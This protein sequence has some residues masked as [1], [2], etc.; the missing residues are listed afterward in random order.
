VD[1]DGSARIAAVRAHVSALLP[2]KA[3]PRRIHRVNT[4]RDDGLVVLFTRRFATSTRTAYGG[5]EVVLDLEGKLAPNG[6]QQ[7]RVLK[8]RKGGGNTTLRWGQAV[9]SV[10][11]PSQ[12][13]VYQLRVGQRFELRTQ[14]V[15][16]VDEPCGG[17]TAV[18][19]GW[20]GVS[21][22]QG[23]NYFTLR[24]GR[25]AAPSRTTYASGSQ[26]HPRTGLGITADGRVL[27]VT[28]DGRRTASAGVTLAEMGQLMRSLGAVHA[29]NLDGGGS[30]V[31]ARHK[32]ATGRFEVANRPSDGRQRPATQAFAVFALGTQS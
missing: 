13:W 20:A 4:H 31:M 29:F 5:V 7:V 25:I 15:R 17:T 3:V 10:R 9:L 16:R 18:A 27:M 11:D 19:P 8:V 2:G 6:V 24:G 30:T 21:E 28:V 12:R 26:R 32:D 23:G 1:P 22:A 14:V